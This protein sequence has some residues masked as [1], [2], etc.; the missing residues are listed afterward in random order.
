MNCSYYWAST[1][2][3]ALLSAG[4]DDAGCHTGGALSAAGKKLC[5]LYSAYMRTAYFLSHPSVVGMLLKPWKPTL[6]PFWSPRFGDDFDC[7][8]VGGGRVDLFTAQ[9][10]SLLHREAPAVTDH[11]YRTGDEN[12]ADSARV[13]KS[14]GSRLAILPLIGRL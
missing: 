10:F 8:P 7:L 14:A 3:Q 2:L 13:R 6:S 12:G 11:R 9:L 4:G 5:A 1:D